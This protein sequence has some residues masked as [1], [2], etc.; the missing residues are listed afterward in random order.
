MVEMLEKIKKCLKEEYGI[1]SVQEL[2]IA[3]EK[4]QKIPIGIFTTDKKEVNKN[5]C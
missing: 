5:E 1:S 3:L 2:A 4:S